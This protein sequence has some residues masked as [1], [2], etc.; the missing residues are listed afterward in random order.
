[1][2][3]MRARVGEQCAREARFHTVEALT[4][5]R[6]ELLASRQAPACRAQMRPEVLEPAP[7][8]ALQTARQLVQLLGELQISRYRPFGG[9]GR[10]RCP[11][12]GGK[13]D[14]SGVGLVSNR[15]DQWDF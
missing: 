8:A 4:R 15:R 12:V 9:L 11:G 13:I 6:Q 1:M 5:Q 14:E 7:G 2:D 3:G 10:R